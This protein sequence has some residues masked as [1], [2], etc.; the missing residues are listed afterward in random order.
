MKASLQ[1]MIDAA[2]IYN[3]KGIYFLH[4]FAHFDLPPAVKAHFY[5]SSVQL[6]MGNEIRNQIR[7]LS[8]F[9]KM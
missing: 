7:V 9:Y 6:Q 5:C 3:L 1:L 8:A 4:S 2:S